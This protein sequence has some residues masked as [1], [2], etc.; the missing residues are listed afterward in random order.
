MAKERSEARPKV[1][2]E[3]LAMDLDSESI[4]DIKAIMVKLGVSPHDCF[5]K[6]VTTAVAYNYTNNALLCTNYYIEYL[7]VPR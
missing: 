1:L 5:E 4:R 7:K 6:K 2:R 3:L